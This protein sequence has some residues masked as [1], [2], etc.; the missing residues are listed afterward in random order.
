M[1]KRWLSL[2]LVLCM[3]LTLLPVST[4]AAEII[5][6]GNC[7]AQGSNITWKLDSNGLLTVTGSGAM[8]DYESAGD[9]KSPFKERKD[10][11]SVLI[12]DGITH[13]G[14]YSFTSCPGLTSVSLPSGLKSIGAHAFALNNQ[15]DSV[16]IPDGVET[17]GADAFSTCR[18]LTSIS[19]P[20]SITAIGNS[21]FYACSS[22]KSINLPYGI[23]TLGS[24]ALAFCSSLTT[25]SIPSSVTQI[26]DNLFWGCSSLTSVSIPNSIT[27]IGKNVFSGCSALQKITI[28]ISVKTIDRSAFYN[29]TGLTYIELPGSISVI[30]SSTFSGCSGLTGILIPASVTA[31]NDY[32]F[33]NCGAL[34]DV[35]YTGTREQWNSI[36]IGSGNTPLQN[37]TIHFDPVSEPQSN[38]LIVRVKA[39]D[40]DSGAKVNVEGATVS[41]YY[42]SGVKHFNTNSNGVARVTFEGMT[43]QQIAKSTISAHKSWSVE[44]DADENMRFPL[45]KLAQSSSGVPQRYIYELHSESLD[46]NGNWCGKKI[47]DIWKSGNTELVLSEPRLLINVSVSYYEAAGT[48]SEASKSNEQTVKDFLSNYSL[49]LAQS[50]DGHV[51]VNKALIGKTGSRNDFYVPA[52][53]TAE[54]DRIPVYGS[55]KLASM[56]D[57]RVETGSADTTS[58]HSNASIGGF[59]SNHDASMI[60]NGYIS[61]HFTKMSKAEKYGLQCRYTFPRIQCAWNPSEADAAWNLNNKLYV[62]TT[63]ET[64]HYLMSFFD[65]YINGAGDHWTSFWNNGFG[66]NNPR[67]N[68]APKNFGLMDYQYT[69]AELSNRNDYSYLNSTGHG[70]K[71]SDTNQSY[72]WDMSCEDLLASLLTKGT[73]QYASAFLIEWYNEEVGTNCSTRN[74]VLQDILTRDGESYTW[75]EF[76]T[77]TVIP[78]IP[79][80]ANYSKTSGGEKRRT[81]YSY[82]ALDSADY[83]VYDG[84]AAGSSYNANNIETGASVLSATSPDFETIS[85]ETSGYLYN[86]LDNSIEAYFIPDQA[87][88]FTFDTSAE[89]LAYEDYLS[90]NTS[91]EISTSIPVEVKGELYSVAPVDADIDYSTISWFKLNGETWEQ[92]QTDLISEENMNIGARCDYDGEGTYVLMAKPA[93]AE[94]L[95]KVTGI[96]CKNVPDQEGV[97]EITFTDPNFNSTHDN[98]YDTAYY[99]VYFSDTQFTDTESSNVTMQMFYAGEGPY[100]IDFGGSHF[101]GYIAVVAVAANGAKSEISSVESFTTE[102][103]DRD[104]DGIPDW[105]CDQY[106]LWP[107]TGEEKDIANSDDDGDGLTNLQEYLDG[108]DPTDPNDPVPVQTN[109][110]TDVP[111]G[112]FY[113]DAVLWAV[114]HDPQITTGVTDTTFMPD[115]VCT[116]AHVV[117]FLWRANG[118]PEPKST[119]NTFK[120]VPNG[121]YYT[122]AVLWASEQG[123]TTGYSDGTFRPDAECTRAQVVTFLWR[124]NGSPN[125]TSTTNPFKDVPAGKYYAKA[126]LWALENGV[127]TGKTATAFN[128]DGECT[129]AHVVTFLYRDM[130]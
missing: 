63:H 118:C 55:A 57:I 26:T 17:I 86:S 61:D 28:P 109:P 65:E 12:S 95:E 85:V 35:Y 127:T 128:P 32:A 64:G 97:V 46:S 121:K 105:Y 67:P 98:L 30:N 108:T 116:R 51:V 68:K 62:T 92:L 76:S 81:A 18:S 103:T 49:Q 15:L 14:N 88:E 77:V 130:A 56:A 1:K 125:P 91:V 78:M 110:F 72:V 74:D 122:K 71:T 104:D 37:A 2:A 19:I 75:D 69:E 113:T 119:T 7:G 50:T 24:H 34:G 20:T 100:M 6:S 66:N 9:E 126:V 73:K 60:D 38:S 42:D 8:K 13:I 54:G 44:P 29:F 123:I 47:Q 22:L 90:V 107:P 40:K 101:T 117:T 10:I 124:A 23:K 99:E 33:S 111:D 58:V 16:T 112:K 94:S 21:A 5:E 39:L 27:S 11:I 59:F 31:I 89:K 48:S 84:S 4:F 87:C 115:R 102:E 120:D 45:Q 83:I 36:S 82:A 114:S 53:I 96:Y 3:A 52:M 93:Q 41:L 79:Y 106:L 25:V 129:R 80:Q 43:E 70:T